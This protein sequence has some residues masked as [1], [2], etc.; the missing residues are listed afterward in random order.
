MMMMVMKLR[1]MMKSLIEKKNPTQTIHWRLMMLIVNIMV[2]VM[3]VRMI[4]EMLI[5]AM[6]MVRSLC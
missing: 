6:M 3:K 4:K 5:M 2:R 1:I